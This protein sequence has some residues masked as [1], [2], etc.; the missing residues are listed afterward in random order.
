VGSVLI[1]IIPAYS[2]S[3][4]YRYLHSGTNEAKQVWKKLNNNSTEGEIEILLQD[5]TT[6]D[7]FD[8][9]ITCCDY[10]QEPMKT[11]HRLL[12]LP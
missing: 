5:I 3:L 6:N 8:V 4:L 12:L 10:Q 1:I 9:S 2:I 7:I 11:T